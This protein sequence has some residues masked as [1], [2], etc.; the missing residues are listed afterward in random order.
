MKTASVRQ[1]R[2]AFPAVLRHIRNGETVRILLRN[3]PVA[4][5]TP[6]KPEPRKKRPRPWGDLEQRFAELQR[7]PAISDS[8][9]GILSDDRERFE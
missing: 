7:R 9:A 8:G 6:P 5:L 2:N 1:L 4:D 3:K